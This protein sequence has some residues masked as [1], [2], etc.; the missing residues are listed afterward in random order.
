MKKNFLKISLAFCFLAMLGV[1]SVNLN[2]SDGGGG[3]SPCKY[4]SAWCVGM[5]SWEAYCVNLGWN[6]NTSCT[7]GEYVPCENQDI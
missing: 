2:A 4:W 7:C 1:S 6:T 3:G 5:S